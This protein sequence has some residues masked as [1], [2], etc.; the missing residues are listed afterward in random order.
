MRGLPDIDSVAVTVVVK[1][2]DSHVDF[3]LSSFGA[4][5]AGTTVQPVGTVEHL[6]VEKH[7][8][9]DLGT[10]HEVAVG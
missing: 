7:G 3:H 5:E 8:A 4:M 1:E 10:A 2:V 9:S 6:I